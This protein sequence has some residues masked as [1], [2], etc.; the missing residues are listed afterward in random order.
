[1][2]D[3]QSTF[4]WSTE[5]SLSLNPTGM[6]ELKKATPSY[7]AQTELLVFLVVLPQRVEASSALVHQ[8]VI[9]A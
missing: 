9:V 2:R 6:L 3:I 1:M 8:N 4:D 5:K 7:S